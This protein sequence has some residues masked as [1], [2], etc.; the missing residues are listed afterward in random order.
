MV[1]ASDSSTPEVEVEESGVQGGPQ[2]YTEFEASLGHMRPC[3][4]VLEEAILMSM[5]RAEL[6][7]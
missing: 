7:N 4:I 1:P 6:T 5:S 3:L 2:L